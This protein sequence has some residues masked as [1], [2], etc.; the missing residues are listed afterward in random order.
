MFINHPAGMPSCL[1]LWQVLDQPVIDESALDLRDRLEMELLDKKGG[2]VLST[3]GT[4]S[5][6]GPGH[7]DQ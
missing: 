3:E 4:P 2:T 6:A 1:N 7:R 5:L